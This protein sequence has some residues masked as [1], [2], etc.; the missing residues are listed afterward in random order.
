MTRKPQN[1]ASSKGANTSSSSNQTKNQTKD[2]IILTTE[3]DEEMRDRLNGFLMLCAAMNIQVDQCFDIG[4][5]GALG[6]G[7]CT[8]KIPRRAFNCSDAMYL[9]SP[10]L[11]VYMSTPLF[12]SHGWFY[13][14]SLY[15]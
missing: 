8:T 9:M 4:T 14:S 11:L 2:F 10:F 1:R 6:G 3:T 12:H 13:F 15:L 7:Y 5:R